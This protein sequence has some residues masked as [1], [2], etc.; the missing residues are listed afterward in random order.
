MITF[1]RTDQSVFGRWWWTVDRWQLVA[2][3]ILMAMGTVL[4]TAASPPVAERIGIDDTFYFVERHLLMLVPASIIMMSVSLL[5]PRG[6]ARTAVVVYLVALALVAATLVVGVEIKGARRW[7]HIPGLSLQPSEFVKP[8]FAV[9][10][11][12]LFSLSRTTPG[13]PGSF[14][15]MVL[16]GGTVGLLLMQPDLGMAFVLS[17]VWFTQF[18]LAGLNVLLVVALG[19]LGVAGLVMAYFTFPH[20]T[21]RIDR[22]LDPQAGD[23]YQV[24]R[25]LEAFANGGLMGTGPG[26]GTVKFSLPDAHADFIFAVAGEE[27]GLV[28]CLLIVIT[29]GFIVLRGFARVFNENNY[30]V[31]LATAGLLV[32]FG[33]QSM[34]NMGS[35]LHLMPTKGMTLP[36]ISYGGSSLLAL[37]FGMGM[38]LALTRKRFGPGD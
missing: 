23:T 21:S 28:A 31:I 35:S 24:S 37:G 5:S 20:V 15:S 22:F 38:V 17:A 1:D 11:A 36:F 7:I 12:W 6:V 26:Q 16:Y 4:I 14:V 29:F 9:V 10:A 30:F 25:S 32:Q 8:A 13:F 27:L 33:L 18:F 19:V 34:I 2:L 3:A